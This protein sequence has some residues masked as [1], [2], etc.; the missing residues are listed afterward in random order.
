MHFFFFKTE[1]FVLGFLLQPEGLLQGCLELH[2]SPPH[3]SICDLSLS[4]QMSFMTAWSEHPPL[5]A[6]TQ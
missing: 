5:L 6:I 4:A 1:C 3:L 2:P